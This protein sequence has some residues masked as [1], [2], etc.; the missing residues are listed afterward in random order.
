MIKDMEK[1]E[2]IIKMVELN[3]KVILSKINMKEKVNI[4]LK[5]V[6]I[7]LVNGQIVYSMVKEYYIIKKAI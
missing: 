6:T 7:I 5:M 4:F 1:G 3:T 2:Y